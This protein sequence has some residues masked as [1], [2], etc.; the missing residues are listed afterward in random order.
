MLCCI[1]L[2]KEDQH[3]HKS[4]R[5]YYSLNL[6]LFHKKQ[7]SVFSA[8]HANYFFVQLNPIF[9]NSGTSTAAALSLICTTLGYLWE[10]NNGM[11]GLGWKGP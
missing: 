11:N 8:L 9:S 7:F 3:H 2:L 1:I 10:V 6:K 4:L 5:D